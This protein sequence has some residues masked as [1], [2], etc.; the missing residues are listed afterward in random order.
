[1]EAGGGAPRI[2]RVPRLVPP[3]ASGYDIRNRRRGLA[4]RSADATA[5]SGLDRLRSLHLND[6]MTP[7]GSNRDRHAILGEGELGEPGCA[8]FLSEPR[9][10]QLPCV[11]ETP[12][13]ERQGPAQEEVALCWAAP[14]RG[15]ASRAR[16]KKS[17][18][19]ARRA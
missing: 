16:T 14:A 8:A 19:R 4:A 13:P 1:M 6:S 9:F 2:A 11:L 17:S 12:G 18:S 7:L 5:P 15:R 10:E 3:V